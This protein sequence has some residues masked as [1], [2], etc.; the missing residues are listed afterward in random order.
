M[1]MIIA[2]RAIEEE[3]FS[4][5]E[6]EQEEEKYTAV[7]I[8]SHRFN[9]RNE[10]SYNV[11]WKSLDDDNREEMSSDYTDTPGVELGSKYWKERKD[12]LLEITASNEDEKVFTVKTSYVKQRKNISLKMPIQYI[13]KEL[14]VE[15][16]KKEKSSSQ[17]SQQE[18]TEVATQESVDLTQVSQQETTE[19]EA[20]SGMSTQVSEVPTEAA[21]QESG[22]SQ[23]SGNESSGVVDLVEDEEGNFIESPVKNY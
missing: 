9:K 5:K 15:F 11:M 21:T 12:K 8:K 23:E 18:T 2:N 17:V 20:Q 7:S 16:K 19:V 4:Q 10:I 13:N 3:Y 1:Q 6:V 22:E 14:Y